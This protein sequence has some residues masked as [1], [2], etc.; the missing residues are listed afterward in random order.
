MS[1]YINAIRR[2]KIE[3]D[4]IPEHYCEIQSEKG[5][6]AEE[7]KVSEA[8][9]VNPSEYLSMYSPRFRSRFTFLMDI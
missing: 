7:T 8:D 2:R 6:P 1:M 9:R 3:M 4:A 5:C